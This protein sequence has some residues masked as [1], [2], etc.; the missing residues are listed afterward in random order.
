[1]RAGSEISSAE[2][3]GRRHASDV[4][5]MNAVGGGDSRVLSSSRYLLQPHGARSRDGRHVG[6]VIK[7]VTQTNTFRI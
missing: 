3:D 6:V 7:Q 5:E 2:G 1:M 4:T